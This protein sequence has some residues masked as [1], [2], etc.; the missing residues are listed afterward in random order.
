MFALEKYMLA[1]IQI[2]LFLRSYQFILQEQA[3]KDLTMVFFLQN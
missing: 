2:K 3:H 1:F